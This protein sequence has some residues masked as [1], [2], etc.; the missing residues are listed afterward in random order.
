MICDEPLRR[1]REAEERL[2]SLGINPKKAFSDLRELAEFGKLKK[3][4]I[5]AYL[6]YKRAKSELIRCAY[7]YVTG[8][9]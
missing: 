2:W 8:L 4:H 5:V 7:R 3:E 1:L 9:E 6:E